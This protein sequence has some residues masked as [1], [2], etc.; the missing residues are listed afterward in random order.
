RASLQRHGA[1]WHLI[2]ALDDIAWLLNLRGTDIPYN[3]V[4]LAHALIGRETARLFIDAAKLP[5][6][7]Q[8]EL[9]ADGITLE[10]YE[11]I[12][13]ALASLPEGERLLIDPARVAVSLAETA[14]H[15]DKI[16]GVNPAHLL[17]SRKN[18]AETANVR[19]TM[20]HDGAALCEFF[21]WFESAQ[22]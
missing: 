17:K 9:A 20:E 4:F 12:A 11:D 14:A 8:A 19:L 5:E 22:G 18:E 16:E 10:P 1:H 6:A 13:S 7:L 15:V 2:S 3:P 21:A